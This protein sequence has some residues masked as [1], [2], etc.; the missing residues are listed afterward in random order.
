MRFLKTLSAAM[1]VAFFAV[2]LTACQ[3]GSS[4]GTDTDAGADADEWISLFNGETLEGWYNPYDWGEAWV[5][6]GE[7]RLTA[8]EKFFLVTDTTFSDFVLEL[9]VRVP[10]TS[11]NSGII[12]RANVEPDLV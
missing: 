7:I 2:G 9:D 8:D 12:F 6:N 3:S 10:D 1:A 5:E 11:A 4:S